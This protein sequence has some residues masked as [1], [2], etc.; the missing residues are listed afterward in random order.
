MWR[1]I[2]QQRASLTSQAPKAAAWL[3]CSLGFGFLNE[4]PTQM[5]TQIGLL[6]VASGLTKEEEGKKQQLREAGCEGPF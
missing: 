6:N 1:F 2:L 3:F 4:I 5:F